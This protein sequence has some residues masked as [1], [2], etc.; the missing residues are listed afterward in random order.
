MRAPEQYSVAMNEVL[1]RD[2]DN[3]WWQVGVKSH[4]P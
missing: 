2:G 3:S 1:E 4:D